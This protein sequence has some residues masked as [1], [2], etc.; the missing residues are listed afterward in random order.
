MKPELRSVVEIALHQWGCLW[1]EQLRNLLRVEIEPGSVPARLFEAHGSVHLALVDLEEDVLAPLPCWRMLT[2]GSYYLHRLL[3]HL[4][5]GPPVC[6]VKVD[7]QHPGPP[8]EELM[9][10]GREL[11]PGCKFTRK[12]T[13]RE[14]RF[15]AVA[16]HFAV[17][18]L[19]VEPSS[20]IVTITIDALRENSIPILKS[21]G[22]FMPGEPGQ[23]AMVRL[24]STF[25]VAVDA[26]RIRIA[27]MIEE[28]SAS[29]A[30][31][32]RLALR[33]LTVARKVDLKT[34]ARGEDESE[35]NRRKAELEELWSIREREIR[36]RA[37]AER[38][39]VALVAA[40]VES[41]P[42]VFYTAE[43]AISGN[44]FR[45]VRRLFDQSSGW[46]EP[47][48]CESCRSPADLLIPGDSPCF[49]LICELCSTGARL[50][51]KHT[52]CHLCRQTCQKCTLPVCPVCSP[53]CSR[54]LESVCERHSRRCLVCNVRL[55]PRCY[56]RCLSC[57]GSFCDQ[58]GIECPVCDNV[59]CASH[60]RHQGNCYEEWLQLRLLA[61]PGQALLAST[62]EAWFRPL[63]LRD[64]DYEV[65]EK[66]I[67]NTIDNPPMI[68]TA[69]ASDFEL[70]LG[71]P[72]DAF[73]EAELLSLDDP[74]KVWVRRGAMNDPFIQEYGLIPDCET[75]RRG[76]E[77]EDA[78]EMLSKGWFEQ[79]VH[80]DPIIDEIPF[81]DAGAIEALW[82]PGGILDGYR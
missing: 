24:E 28:Y 51:C 73:S 23:S 74:S 11:S 36:L 70:R 79:E 72:Q 35:R 58:H 68:T 43:V 37:G 17:R 56:P 48:R 71:H 33:R 12:A 10:A 67:Q 19:G 69:T 4:R 62:A 78:G 21:D 5:S 1:E 41:R 76:V 38:A 13:A 15:T 75:L 18:L 52:L 80:S 32:T 47:L 16:Y 27:G 2:P 60:T 25:L 63:V 3:E 64:A 45:F 7:D 22:F 57:H 49:H 82:E 44:R 39:E 29:R 54:C 61:L 46:I 30:R 20:E 50:A 9:P 26:L 65:L 59:I 55:C 77:F 53:R 8:V 42:A 14:G 40:T 34:Q 66:N 31:Q 6:R 81:W